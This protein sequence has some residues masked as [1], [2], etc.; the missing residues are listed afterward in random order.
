MTKAANT[1]DALTFI[2]HLAQVSEGIAFQANVG[3]AA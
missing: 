3:G 1:I 2:E